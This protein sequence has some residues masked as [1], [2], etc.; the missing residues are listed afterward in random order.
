MPRIRSSDRV[1]PSVKEKTDLEILDHY[2]LARG[3]Y[4][5][6]LG[7]LCI[8]T[9]ADRN[10]LGTAPVV[11]VIKYDEQQEKVNK[12]VGDDYDLSPVELVEAVWEAVPDFKETYEIPDGLLRSSVPAYDELARTTTLTCQRSGPPALHAARRH[13]PQSPSGPP[14]DRQPGR[15]PIGVSPQ[16]ILHTT[17]RRNDNLARLFHDLKLMEREGSGFDRMYEV[18][19]SQGRPVPELREGTDRVEVVVRRRIISARAVDIIAKVDAAYQLR[20]RETICLGLLAQH[21]ALDR[22]PASRVARAARR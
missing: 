15:L 10:R 1:K 6:N 22:P 20:Q 16:N 13:L 18:L 17:V 7:I 8:G 2:A 19:L 3:P 14:S 12:L 9:Q 4:L 11:Q 21:E 5:T